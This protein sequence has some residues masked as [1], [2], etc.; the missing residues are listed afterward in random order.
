MT[1]QE[2]N[3]LEVLH[4]KATPGPWEM[5]EE[6]GP[7]SFIEITGRSGRHVCTVRLFGFEHPVQWDNGRF[8]VAAHTSVP[9]LIA[10]VRRLQKWLEIEHVACAEL[11]ALIRRHFPT[12]DP[13]RIKEADDEIGEIMGRLRK[14]QLQWQPIETAPAFKDV[15][16]WGKGLI[17][18]EMAYYRSEPIMM[19]GWFYSNGH[20][21]CPSV[22]VFTHWMPL[23]EAPGKEGE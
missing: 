10:E 17:D 21:R 14:G 23:P 20:E 6:G 1:D 3:A 11:E 8:I 15:L 16:V 9:A 22:L 7:C 5:E 19:T 18:P 2:L 4:E 13:R 12:V